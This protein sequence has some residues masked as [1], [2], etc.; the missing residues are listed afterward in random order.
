MDFT[1]IGF[2][3][4]LFGASISILGLVFIP[5]E[6]FKK[7]GLIFL[8]CGLVILITGYSICSANPFRIY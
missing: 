1:L 8:L 2:V 6:K 7:L 5:I 3:I 4:L